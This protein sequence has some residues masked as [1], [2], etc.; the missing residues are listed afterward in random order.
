MKK[1]QGTLQPINW[2]L[3]LCPP[4]VP[5][6]RLCTFVLLSS[7]CQKKI[8][9][10]AKTLSTLALLWD[11]FCIQTWGSQNTP[12]KTVCPKTPLRMTKTCECFTSPPVSSWGLLANLMYQ[13]NDSALNRFYSFLSQGEWIPATITN[14]GTRWE[15]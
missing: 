13:L 1:Q 12:K 10:Y 3:L 8:S 7:S 5:S 15:K 9:F 6:K 11:F 14:S 2:G 4:S